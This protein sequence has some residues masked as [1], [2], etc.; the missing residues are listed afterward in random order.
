MIYTGARREE[1]AQLLVSDVCQDEDSG[2][3]HLS[4]AP[5]EGKTVK[6][7][8]SRRRVPLHQDLLDLGLLGYRD[9]LPTSGRLFPKLEEHPENGYGHAV[10]KAWAKYLKEVVSL[11]SQA[12]LS[13]GFRYTF[14]TICREVGI[15]TAV[16]DWITGHAAPNV[17][18]SYGTNPLC[19]MLREL[20]KYPSI[21]RAAGLH[22]DP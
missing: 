10:G 15:E 7:A 3:W 14:K 8:S 2:I 5:G 18:A 11:E 9:S 22:E 1:L 19:R 6:T 12:S 13:H 16:S 4:I 20:A 21:A 17:G